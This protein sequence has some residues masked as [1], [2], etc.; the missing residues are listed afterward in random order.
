M[1]TQTNALH[2][3]VPLLYYLAIFTGIRFFSQMHRN[4]TDLEAR[5]MFYK[6]DKDGDGLLSMAEL[7]PILFPKVRTPHMHEL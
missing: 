2:T 3:Y 1:Y 4:I 6:L 7:V 5:K